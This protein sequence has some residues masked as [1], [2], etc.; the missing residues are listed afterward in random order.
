MILIL[1]VLNLAFSIMIFHQTRAQ[2]QPQAT[3][4]PGRKFTAQKKEPRIIAKSEA[5]EAEIEEARLAKLGWDATT[6][7]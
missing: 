7:T 3:K 5:R 1:L 4:K 2:Y 6:P